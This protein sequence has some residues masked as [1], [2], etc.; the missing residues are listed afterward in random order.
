MTASFMHIT[1]HPD[2]EDNSLLVML[3]RGRGLRTALLTLTRGEGGQNEIGPELFQAL[4]IIRTEE[5]MSMHR[6]DG[7]EQFFTRAYDF[8]YSFSIE[9][10]FEKWGKEE[11]LADVVRVI[12]SF[13]PEVIVTLPRTGV[14]GGQHH[15]ASGLLAL[16]AFRA[17]ADPSRFPEQIQKGLHP[18]QAKKIYERLGWAPGGDDQIQDECPLVTVQ[19]GI[20]DPLLGRSYYQTGMEARSYHRCQGMSQIIPPPGSY[21]SHWK[22]IDSTIPIAP[23]ESDLF[24][25]ID[26]SLF[27]IEAY[28]GDELAN[29]SFLHGGLTQ[30]QGHIDAAVNA[31]DPDAPEKTASALAAGLNTVHALRAQVKAASLKDLSKY[32]VLLMLE[33]KEKDFW[34]ALQLARQLHMDVLV[35]EGTVVPG[36]RFTLRVTIANGSPGNVKLRAIRVNTPPGWQ[37]DR[38]GEEPRH[39]SGH[40]IVKQRYAVTVAQ[41]SELTRPYWVRNSPADR[42]HILKP[43]H[44]TKSWSPPAVTVDVLYETDG[45]SAELH[46]PAQYPYEGSWVGGEQRH[47]LTVAPALSLRVEPK[48]CILSLEQASQ[49]REIQVSAIYRGR[50]PATGKVSFDLPPGWYAFPSEQDFHFTAVG[51]SITKRFHITPPRDITTGQFE[52]AVIGNLK[53]RIYREDLQIIDYHHIQQRLLYHPS[54]VTF[55]TV[56]VKVA[57]GLEIG[58]IMGVGDQV[59]E[60]LK[61]LGVDFQFL[62]DD[63]LTFGDLKRYDVIITGVRAYLNREA[64]KANNSR[65]LNWVKEGGVMVVQYNKFEFNK[66]VQGPDGPHM[67]DSPYAPYPAQVSR[68]RVTDEN[69]PIQLLDS[70]STVFHWPNKMTPRDW[71][72]WVQERGLYFL[73]KK[74]RRYRDLLSTEDSFEYNPGVKQG[75][76]VKAD[77]GRGAWFYMGLGLWRQLPAGVPG[78]YRLLANL[79]SLPKTN[80]AALKQEP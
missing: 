27:A 8:G 15:Q 33:H 45:A 11:I 48:L 56:D 38:E 32:Q 31:F 78:A 12:R 44:V 9:E 49:G 80:D 4:G 46:Q 17:A 5:L 28:A 77:Y 76:L 79:I 18:W 37:I 43:A 53:G 40:S 64:L 72:H 30:I 61:Q 21:A 1:A 50:Q 65:L 58:Y 71:D 74:D 34:K 52:I 39:I 73:G 22:L 7:A 69:A 36:E 6:Y 3:G 19:T 67:G 57:P 59:P 20:A 62:N 55:K 29:I 25:G 13:R 23:Y 75:V 24:D 26:T 10:T 63:D 2:D 16:E 42:Y 54:V 35:D 68:A 60:A 47:E 66:K 51:Q 41:N 70:T 14:G